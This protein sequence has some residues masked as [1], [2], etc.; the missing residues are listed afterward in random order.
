MITPK[1]ESVDFLDVETPRK[2]SNAANS[3][4]I[5]YYNDKGIGTD[6][7]TKKKF[8]KEKAKKYC[9]IGWLICIK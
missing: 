6:E 8:D 5:Y 9:C 1:K 3:T 2:T 4:N 7:S